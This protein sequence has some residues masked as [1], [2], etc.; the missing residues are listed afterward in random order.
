MIDVYNVKNFER[1]DNELEEFLLFTIV[2]AGKTAL[3]Q[4]RQLDLFLSIY[5]EIHS[6]FDKIRK[7]IETDKLLEWLQNCK[8]GQYTRL[9]A[10][11]T[12]LVNKK[13]DLRLCTTEDLESIKG[14][15]FKT[16]RF[17]IVYTRPT[18]N[19]CILDTHILKFIRDFMGREDAPKSTPG[20]LNQYIYW[21]KVYLDFL[22]KHN[23]DNSTFDLEIWT[24]YNKKNGNVQIQMQQ[25]T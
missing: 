4:A 3:I 16:S 12:Q 23:L 7:L 21:E 1:T 13:L 18:T 8:L 2:V 20:T 15:G 10:C 24:S 22:L 11:F 6:P 19:Y 17:F 14:I 25:Y 5:S 9:T